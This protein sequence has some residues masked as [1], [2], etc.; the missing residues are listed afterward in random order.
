MNKSYPAFFIRGL[1]GD[2]MDSDIFKDNDI[3]FFD[4]RSNFNKRI[5]FKAYLLDGEMCGITKHTHDY[6]Q[7][8]YVCKGVCSHWINNNEHRMVKGDLFVIPPYVVHQMR[9][10]KDEDVKIIGIEFST[11]FVSSEYDDFTKNKGFFDF[12]Y[13]EPFLVS[14]DMVKPKLV[15]SHEAQMEVE[16]LT[17]EM[18]K[19]YDSE[20]RYYELYIKANLLKLLAVIAREYAKSPKDKESDEIFDK[21]RNAI[22]NSIQ[23]I[24]DNFTQDLHLDDVCKHS[25]MSK[26]YFCY[27]FKNLT[28]KTFTEFHTELRIQKALELLNTTDASITEICYSVGYNDVTHFCRTFKKQVGV[29]PR[30]YR[31]ERAE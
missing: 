14:K 10:I 30:L 24:K 7:I 28:G 19:E 31:K 12:A 27:V 26:T 3:S 23:Y 16:K 4:S 22:L 11:E 21:Y 20:E 1:S 17:M 2:Y 9:K 25:M 8:W 29:S 13:L 5:P 18:L 6:I 15:L